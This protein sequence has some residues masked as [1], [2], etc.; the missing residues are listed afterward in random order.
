M[1]VGG[2]RASLCFPGCFVD[3]N[4][5]LVL[6]VTDLRVNIVVDSDMNLLGLST[7]AV[8]SLAV[9]VYFNLS[10]YSCCRTQLFIKLVNFTFL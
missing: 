3:S 6:R 2:T 5:Q 9:S 4:V 8:P 7:K 1:S 10:A